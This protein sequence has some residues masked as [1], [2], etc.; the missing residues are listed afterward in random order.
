MLPDVQASAADAAALPAAGV[1]RLRM[2]VCFH[3]SGDHS[4][5]TVAAA[6]A[7]AAVPAGQRGAH[8]SR[9]VEQLLTLR[10]AI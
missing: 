4:Q 2:P 5:H 7:W 6:A 9:L 3:D 1:R 8:M 10:A